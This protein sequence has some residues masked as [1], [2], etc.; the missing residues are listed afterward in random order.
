[1]RVLVTGSAGFVGSHLVPRLVADGHEVV[2]TDRELDVTRAE[3]VAERV[4]EIAPHAVVHL[5][6]QS[7]PSASWDAPELTYRVNFLGTRSLLEAVRSRAPQARVLLVGS[8]EQY[9]RGEPG[10]PPFSEASPLRPASPYARSKVAADLL[11][12]AYSERGVDAVRVRAFNH[13]GPGQPDA[14]V[15]PSFARQVAEI[16]GGHRPPTLRVGN[17]DSVRDFL[18]VGDVVDAYVRL[19]D[20]SAPAGAYNVAR[21][22]GFRIGRLLDELIELAG[23]DPDVKPDPALV[24]PTDH[25][26]GDATRLRRTTGWEP[27]T[28]IRSTLEGLL[29]HWRERVDGS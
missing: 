1:M 19:L 20:P 14:F 18:D 24:R 23:I 7:S 12:A 9:G 6:A 22:E 11:G 17:L 8:A 5:A 4:A 28:P 10:S 21:G 27:R 15:L 26:V 16:A 29:A 2:S 13:T 3:R 25:C